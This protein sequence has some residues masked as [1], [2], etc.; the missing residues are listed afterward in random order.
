MKIVNFCSQRCLIFQKKVYHTAT[1]DWIRKSLDFLRKTA[2][3]AYEFG[4]IRKSITIWKADRLC[5]TAFSGISKP[6]NHTPLSCF[7]IDGLK[8]AS[9]SIQKPQIFVPKIINF[10]N[11]SLSYSLSINPK[12]RCTKS[13][14]PCIDCAYKN[15]L[16]NYLREYFAEWKPKRK[17]LSK[18]SLYYTEKNSRFVRVFFKIFYTLFTFDFTITKKYPSIIRRKIQVLLMCFEKKL[19]NYFHAK[20][21]SPNKWGEP[22]LLYCLSIKNA[23]VNIENRT[24]NVALFKVTY[25]NLLGRQFCFYTFRVQYI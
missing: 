2:F 25:H 7:K 13:C 24:C 9:K 21:G 17:R 4:I 5:R 3:T 6:E 18:N 22:Y 19:I 8:S 10:P 11:Q 1:L 20:R 12:A 16:P 14:W 23:K 15:L